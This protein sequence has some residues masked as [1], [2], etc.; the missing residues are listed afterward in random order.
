M[1]FFPADPRLK[2]LCGEVE[3]DEIHRDWGGAHHLDTTEG[4]QTEVTARSECLVGRQKLG[5]LSLA[6]EEVVDG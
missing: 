2:W 5:E 1:C 3:T 4:H 6:F